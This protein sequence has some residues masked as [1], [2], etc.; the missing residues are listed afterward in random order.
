[1][2]DVN[3]PAGY[4]STD[5]GVIPE[6]WEANKLGDIAVIS[7]GG[8]PSRNNP[9]YWNGDIPWITTTRIDFNTIFYSDEFITQLGL[10]NSSAK[11]YDENTLLMA[12]YGQGKTRGKIAILGIKAAI[13]QACASIRI[14]QNHHNKY[15]FYYL[16]SKYEAIRIL[17][18]TGNQENLNGNLIKDI[19]L[20]VPPLPEQKAIARV[21]SDVDELI[22]ECDTLLAKK[23]D[24]KQGT[25]QQLLTGKQRLPGFSGKWE[26]HNITKCCQEIFLGLTAKV[27]Y[28]KYGGV[29]L[30]RATDISSGKLSFQNALFISKQ[31]H[32]QL[33]KYRKAKY[34]DVLV[35]K[36]G[37]LGVCALVETEKEFSIYESIIVLQ[38]V[39]KRLNSNFLLCLMTFQETQKSLLS[40]TVGSTV[41]H[42]NLNL[43]KQLD[44]TLPTI[45][46]QKAIAQI[47]SDMDA[48]I[49]ALEKKRD[50]Y[51][52]IKQGMMQELLTG[53]TRIKPELDHSQGK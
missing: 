36:S 25:M 17:S 33:T 42:L 22:R 13:N 14:N 4:K 44:I 24:I 47:L 8:T 30:I 12:M 16:L 3:V 5:I 10:H 20:L 27:D 1:M 38:P 15:V 48:E 52:A 2:K 21:L 19:N 49:E 39:F 7:S 50:K 6:D 43:F 41:G 46:E 26:V 40:G 51:K 35:S 23:R 11:L 29:P 45:S 53:K 9:S 37:S 34:G 31:Q 32:K 18:N 28:V